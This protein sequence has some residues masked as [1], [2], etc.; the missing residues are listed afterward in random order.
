MRF[1]RAGIYL[2]LYYFPGYRKKT[3]YHNL[4]NAFPDKPTPALNSLARQYY[5]H[6]AQL[7]VEVL[8]T[9]SMRESEFRQHIALRNPQLLTAA[10]AQSNGRIMLLGIHQGNWEWMLHGIQSHSAITFNP[11]YKPLHNRDANTFMLQIRERFGACAITGA[12]ISTAVLKNRNKPCALAILADQSPTEKERAVWTSLFERNTPFHAGFAELAI[13]GGFTVLFAQCRL[14]SS[15][16]YEVEFH[17]VEE[18]PYAEDDL[19]RIVVR[20]A[21]LTEAAIKEQPHTWLWSNRRWK[22]TARDVAGGS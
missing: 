18:A 20:Y 21:Q 3:V 13:R 10:H 5:R 6:L 22:R 7:C 19:E 11:V 2:A 12:A 1:L 14:Q 17:A 4:A 8:T 16:H 9:A 15:G